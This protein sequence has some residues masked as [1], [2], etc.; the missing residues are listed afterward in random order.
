[1]RINDPRRQAGCESGKNDGI[2][3]GQGGCFAKKPIK[4]R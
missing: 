1:L 3:H 4:A 2:V